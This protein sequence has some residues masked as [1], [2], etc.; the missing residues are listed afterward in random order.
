MDMRDRTIYVVT[1]VGSANS[2]GSM[3]TRSIKLADENAYIIAICEPGIAP[4]LA[5]FCDQFFNCDLSDAESTLK[6]AA[7]IAEVNPMIHRLINCA[8]VNRMDWFDNIDFFHVE[9]VMSVNCYSQ[10]WMTRG[11]LPALAQAE[12]TVLNI[13]SMGAHKP[14]RTSLA[15]NISK[16]AARM[17]TFQLAR[18]LKLTHNVTV[19]GISPNEL[20]GTGMTLENESSIMRVRGWSTDEVARNRAQ[21]EQTNP[22]QLADFIA[23]ILSTDVAHKH[24]NGVDLYYGD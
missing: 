17:A 21:G 5:Q 16:A 6:L 10:I 7:T 2:L 22:D 12:G 9:Q 15:Y 1:G 11:L 4:T 19:F 8:G 14:F 3:I 23:Y 13:L 20:E 24:F 18:E